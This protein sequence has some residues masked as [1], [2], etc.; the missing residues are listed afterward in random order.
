MANLE[1][2]QETAHAYAEAERHVSEVFL[3]KET[4]LAAVHATYQQVM[5]EL[6]EEADRLKAKLTA[7]VAESPEHFVSPKTRLFGNVKVGFHKQPATADTEGL[8]DEELARRVSAFLPEKF[9]TLVSVRTQVAK[10]G[11]SA[12]APAELK[13]LGLRLKGGCDEP[14]VTLIKQTR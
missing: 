7:Q 4:D 3:Q 1:T 10:K 2:I 13:R 8:S 6:T 9:E 5:T 12:L 14:L 11:L